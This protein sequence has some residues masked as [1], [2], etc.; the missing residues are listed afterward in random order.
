MRMKTTRRGY[1][2][3]FLC[4][5]YI[6]CVIFKHF[7]SA[8]HIKYTY[9]LA[10]Y[11]V[12]FG[13]WFIFGF[14]QLDKVPIKVCSAEL[15]L[16]SNYCA[17]LAFTTPFAFCLGFGSFAVV[18]YGIYLALKL[19]GCADCEED[20]SDDETRPASESSFLETT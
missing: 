2:A 12:L 4:L 16:F 15:F 10:V 19:C 9:E 20:E 3:I 13:S 11:C 1:I 5:C 6:T 18:I 8:R 7:K 17:L 14:E